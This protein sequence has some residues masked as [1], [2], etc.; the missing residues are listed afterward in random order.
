[1]IYEKDNVKID[2]TGIIKV[3]D[4]MVE[5]VDKEIKNVLNESYPRS[6][7]FQREYMGK[8]IIKDNDNEDNRRITKALQRFKGECKSYIIDNYCPYDMD[9]NLED[10]DP[11]TFVYSNEVYVA[12]ERGCRGITCEDCWDK[13]L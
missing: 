13:E 7:D 10:L 5:T 12:H 4:T 1:M 2:T 11:S 3:V 8:W 6:S 9:N